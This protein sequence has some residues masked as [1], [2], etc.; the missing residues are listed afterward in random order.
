MPEERRNVF[1]MVRME[2]KTYQEA[3]DALH[4]SVNTVKYHLKK[5]HAE[6]QEKL[7]TYILLQ[8]TSFMLLLALLEEL[9]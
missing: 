2:N 4:I 9:G 6:L 3:A 1:V 8:I 7:R 5:A